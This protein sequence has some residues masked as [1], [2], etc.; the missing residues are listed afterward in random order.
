VRRAAVV[1]NVV[2][3]DEVISNPAPDDE[4]S[5]GL[6]SREIFNRALEAIEAVGLVHNREPFLGGD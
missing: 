5:F 6:P 4:T 3:E 1:L 2:D